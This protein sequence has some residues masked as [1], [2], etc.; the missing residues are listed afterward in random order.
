MV[1]RP[2]TYHLETLAESR[3]LQDKIQNM[4]NDLNELWSTMNSVALWGISI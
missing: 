2:T 3:L 4:Q 1:S